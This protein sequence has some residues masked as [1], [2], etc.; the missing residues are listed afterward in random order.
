MVSY[1]SMIE[2]KFIFTSKR[3]QLELFKYW[4]KYNPHALM[5]VTST[6]L[7][8]WDPFYNMN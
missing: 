7:I 8:V 3:D 6:Y 2:L 5:T 4:Q 1:L